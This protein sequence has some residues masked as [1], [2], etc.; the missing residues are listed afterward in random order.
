MRD[1][2]TRARLLALID[3]N[4]WSVVGEPGG[5]ARSTVFEVAV[6]SDGTHLIVK[7][8]E[9]PAEAA[10]LRRFPRSPRVMHSDE[11]TLV[12]ELVHGR[13]LNLARPPIVWSRE[14]EWLT[15]AMSANGRLTGTE[16][17]LGSLYRR[18]LPIAARVSPVDGAAAEA[19]VD[20]VESEPFG[21]CAASID[22]IA[23]NTIVDRGGDWWAIDPWPVRGPS[24]ATWAHWAS[25]RSRADPDGRPMWELQ[26]RFAA[27]APD[28]ARLA[29]LMPGAT[30]WALAARV[31]E[32]FAEPVIA[33]TAECLA[34]WLSV[35]PQML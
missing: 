6:P 15:L 17:T 27:L 24:E 35:W 12:L 10:W 26:N 32:G 18:A 30:M 1:A 3:S 11:T 29:A 22:L 33:E 9:G 13:P 31:T 28:P 8:V 21:A 5:G 2:A 23:K 7:S 4:G 16:A 25:S 19:Y 20:W 34:G 14:H